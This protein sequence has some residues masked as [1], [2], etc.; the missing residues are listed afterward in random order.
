MLLDSIIII[1]GG[2]FSLV[3]CSTHSHD[4]GVNCVCELSVNCDWSE[5]NPFVYY[6]QWPIRYLSVILRVIK[7]YPLCSV[8]SRAL[9]SS[10]PKMHNNFNVSV[11]VPSRVLFTVIVAVYCCL[12]AAAASSKTTPATS[13]ITVNK[14]SG[15]GPLLPPLDD[16]GS[17]GES[18][19]SKELYIGFLAGY[20]HSKV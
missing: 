8:K 15:G 20:S 4:N 6:I 11:V 1:I 10:T 19:S 16:D 13:A 5:C 18:K 14:S 17:G 7:C 12:S 9:T 3:Q 2:R